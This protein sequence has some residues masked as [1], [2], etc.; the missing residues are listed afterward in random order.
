MRYDGVLQPLYPAHKHPY[1]ILQATW[2]DDSRLRHVG[3]AVVPQFETCGK[4]VKKCFLRTEF[5][6]PFS[7][8]TLFPGLFTVPLMRMTDLLSRLKFL[9]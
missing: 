4:R 6:F 7:A 2:I 3:P 9:N 8:L 1:L 5:G